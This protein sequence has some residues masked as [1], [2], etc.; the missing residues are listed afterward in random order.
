MTFQDYFPIWDKLNQDQQD[1]LL[2]ALMLRT[3]AK[4]TVL[5]NGEWTAPVSCW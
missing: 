4:G 5:H 3:V 2:S 1:Q